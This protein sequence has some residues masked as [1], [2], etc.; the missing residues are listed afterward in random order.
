MLLQ[1]SAQLR[2]GVSAAVVAAGLAAALAVVE[3]AKPAGSPPGLPPQSV[4]SIQAAIDGTLPVVAEY[5]YRITG[6]V[7]LLLFWVSKVG[8]GGA[9]IRVRRGGRDASGL[10]L[11]IGSDPKRAP[12]AI[13]RWG[14]ILEETRGDETTVVGLM[15]KSDEDTL[16]QATSN[17]AREAKGGVVFKMI[18]ATVTPVESVA[19]VTT[20]TVPR[21]YSY[22][23]LGPLVDALAADASPPRTRTLAAAPGGRPG[24]LSSIAELIR[25]AGDAVQRTGRPPGK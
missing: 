3:G 19:R 12:R 7:R 21:D 6:K 18:Q 17:V 15:K 14:Y 5:R 2:I 25:D 1:P 22:R 20:A 8:V 23:E 24:L 10:D 13:N 16:D 9:R 11:L 4:S